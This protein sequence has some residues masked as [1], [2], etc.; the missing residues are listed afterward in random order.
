MARKKKR[1]AVLGPLTFRHGEFIGVAEWDEETKLYHGTVRGTEPDVVIFQA[2]HFIC[3]PKTLKD[4]IEDYL[5][6]RNQVKQEP[7]NES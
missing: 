1:T 3:L 6:L 4:S 5:E 7:K 2:D